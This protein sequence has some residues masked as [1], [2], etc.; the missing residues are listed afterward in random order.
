[1]SPLVPEI[2]AQQV[3]FGREKDENKE[4]KGRKD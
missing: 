1:L 2:I 3:K 4:I